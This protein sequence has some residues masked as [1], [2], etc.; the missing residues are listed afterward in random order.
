[1]ATA[2]AVVGGSVLSSVVGSA[3]SDRATRAQ[4]SAAMQANDLQWQM[5]QQQREDLAP[6][7]QAGNE[8]LNK[9]Q[10]LNPQS[11]A[12]DPGYQFRLQQGLNAVNSSASARGNANSG[13]TMK[14]L[15]QY[16]QNF[17]SN[18]YQNAYNRL[19]NLAGLGQT[20]TN[21]GVQS[22]GQY[23][24]AVS[25]NLIGLGNARAA[26]QINQANNFSNLIGQGMLAYGLSQK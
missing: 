16:G 9:L 18:E 14:A 1:M 15:T 17:A 3:A 4:R 6:W 11:L 23:G 5:F 7:R 21:L 20:G 19:A 8:A 13:A 22:A 12:N 25:N 26:S 2:A 10:T 24:Q